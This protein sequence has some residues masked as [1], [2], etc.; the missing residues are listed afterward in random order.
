[1]WFLPAIVIVPVLSFELV[2]ADTE[3]VTVPLPLPLFPDVIVIQLTLEAVHLQVVSEVVTSILYAPPPEGDDW[4]C[5]LM[6]YVQS[7]ACSTVKLHTSVDSAPW[8]A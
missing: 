3:Y 6:E 4:L 7:L 5:G 2:L 1:V 8:F